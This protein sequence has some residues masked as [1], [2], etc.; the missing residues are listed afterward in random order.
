MIASYCTLLENARDLRVSAKC[1]SNCSHQ[2]KAPFPF[3]LHEGL[4]VKI[5]LGLSHFAE[6][7]NAA[8]CTEIAP[9]ES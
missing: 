7:L 1:A 6:I 5:V 2:T 9:Q 8:E 3:C 4:T